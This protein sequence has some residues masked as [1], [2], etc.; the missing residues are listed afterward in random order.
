MTLIM[1]MRDREIR[2]VPVG[3]P[4]ISSKAFKAEVNCSRAGKTRCRKTA[5][6]SVTPTRRVVRWSRRTPKR[7][8]KPRTVWDRAEGLTPSSAAALEKLACSATR[9]KAATAG[10]WSDSR[11]G[12]VMGLL[13]LAS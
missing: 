6:A 2:S 9:A 4:R 12:S 5:P 11:E 10:S 8:S 7:D 3:W 13:S 1:A